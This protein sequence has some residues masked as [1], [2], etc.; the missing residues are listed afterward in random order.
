M[1]LSLLKKRFELSKDEAE[2]ATKGKKTAAEALKR[3]E[4]RWPE[5]LDVTSRLEHQRSVNNFSRLI[6]DAL[7]GVK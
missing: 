1:K 2:D 4:E 7:R 3:T 5:V 6:V